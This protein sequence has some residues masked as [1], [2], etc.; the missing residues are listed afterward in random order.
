M[1]YVT[2][3][4]GDTERGLSEQDARFVAEQLRK[5]RGASHPLAHELAD[6]IEDATEASTFAAPV[7]EL[8]LDE[9][10]KHELSELLDA[11]DLDV[12]L[13]REVRALQRALR[14]ER[15]PGE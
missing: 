12:Q 4:L 7:H 10:E 2:L 9:T 13:T 14:D 15:W 11:L 1:A 6:R 5:R 3:R 8:E